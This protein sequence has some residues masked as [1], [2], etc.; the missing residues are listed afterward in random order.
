[1]N[2][3]D[4]NLDPTANFSTLVEILQYRAL[5]Q[6]SEFLYTFVSGDDDA[7][8]TLTYG[9]LDRQARTIGALLQEQVEPG[10]RALLCYP[11]GLDFIAGFFGCL[12]AGVVAVPAYPPR[13]NRPMAALESIIT[14]AQVSAVLTTGE[15]FGAGR[16]RPLKVPQLDG[17]RWILTDSLVDDD[18]VDWRPAE[19][20]SESLAVLQFTS[21]STNAPKG[22]MLTHRNL[23]HNLGVIARCYGHS[24]ASKG[25]IWLPPYHDM[26]L[27]G[28]ILQPMYA[29]FPVVLMAPNTFLQ[30]PLNW[31]RTIS[32]YQATTSGGPNFAYELCLDKI[33]PKDREGLDLGS[34]KVA[35][36]GA[37]QIDHRTLKRFADSFAACGFR[38][39][40][41]Y[42]CYGL[43]EGTLLVSGGD[44]AAA[45]V[46]RGFD[47][48]AIAQSRVK[49]CPAG[50]KDARM[51][52]GCGQVQG[53]QNVIIVD[54][55]M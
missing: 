43:A 26:G 22:V 9:E 32:R 24:P 37:E 6:P 2:P 55:E 38:R 45:P 13:P 11:P 18:P 44:L 40:A 10:G 31:L 47:R 53:G 15:L 54:P 4:C 36:N 50:A 29:G 33:T 27:I 1:M 28:G 48:T 41:F 8:A 21:G 17:L 25:V 16:L 3:A 52:V 14:H 46:V 49:R 34:W 20:A 30:R 19:T 5:R 39:E 35:F 42:P 12:Y 7:A 51:L 23:L